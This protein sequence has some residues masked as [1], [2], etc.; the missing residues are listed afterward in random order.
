MV[1]EVLGLFR[2]FRTTTKHRRTIPIIL[3]TIIIPIEVLTTERV[4]PE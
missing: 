4:V 2:E 1:D 3:L